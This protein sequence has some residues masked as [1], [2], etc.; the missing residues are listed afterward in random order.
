[1]KKTFAR[2]R[3]KA[4]LAFAFFIFVSFVPA[5]AQSYYSQ[6]NTNLVAGDNIFDIT[7]GTTHTNRA[8]DTYAVTSELLANSVT[9]NAAGENVAV[10]V[11]KIS[12]SQFRIT[13]SAAITG[14]FITAQY[15]GVSVTCN[16]PT[17][18]SISRSG[19]SVTY[20]WT[21][22]G[23]TGGTILTEWSTDGISWTSSAGSPTSPRTATVPNVY[24]VYYRVTLYASPCPAAKSNVL[25][26]NPCTAPTLNSAV[27]NTSTPGT[28]TF[29]WNNNGN[30]FDTVVMEYSTNGGGSW[31]Q[32]C[33]GNATSPRTCTGI[34]N[35]NILVR[36]R[37]NGVGCSVVSNSVSLPLGRSQQPTQAIGSAL[38]DPKINSCGTVCVTFGST[39]FSCAVDD[40]NT[41][42]IGTQIYVKNTTTNA[43]V[44]ATSANCAAFPSGTSCNQMN[45]GIKWIRFVNANSNTIYQVDPSTGI[46]N[47]VYGNCN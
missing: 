32:T 39:N 46:I 5:N 2:W 21:N 26:E 14:A 45:T 6:W 20:N 31:T 40:I 10:Q 24:P 38:P 42:G 27:R 3:K 18:L 28:V 22:N 8:A 34:P 36:I 16:T 35:G 33:S 12:Q 17:L 44:N 30:T 47:G 7:A 23:T 43:W 19:T 11:K 25:V 37:G 4:H 41:V 1:M 29:T 9:V 15:P 13:S